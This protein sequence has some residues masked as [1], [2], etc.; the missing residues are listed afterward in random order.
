[1]N[2]EV[3]DEEVTS[4]VKLALL[5]DKKVSSFDIAVATLKG[6]VKLT[7]FVDNQSQIDYIH[8]LVRSTNGVHSIHD[9]LSIK[10]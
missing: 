2:A 9:E 1:L 8:Q 10:Q 6:D 5:N 4:S 3:K 7:G